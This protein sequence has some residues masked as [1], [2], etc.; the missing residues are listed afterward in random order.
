M[1]AFRSLARAMLKSFLRDRQAVFFSV[2]FPLMFLVLF[3]GIFANQSQSRISM[4]QVGDVSLIDNLPREARAAFDDSFDVEKSDDLDAAIQK[5]RD[6]DVTIA[7]QQQGDQIIAHYSDADQVQSAVAQGT[8]R[9]FI[10]SANVAASGKPPTYTYAGERVEDESLKTIQF[11]TPGLLGW[12]IATS[13]TFGAAVTLVGWRTTR[14]LRRI[15]LSPVTTTSVVAAR[16]GVTMLIALVQMA[17]FV[18][19]GVVAF[20]LQLTGSWYMAVPLLICGTLAFMALGLFAGSV[21]KT[22][23]GA[24]SLAQV[25]VLPMAFLSGSF[26]SLDG[27][28]PWLN[29]TS[30]VLPLRYLN[31]GMLDVM[32]RGLGPSAAVVP[33]LVLLGFAA[34]VI[35]ISSRFFSWDVE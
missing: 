21:S 19:L 31:D 20:G 3:G 28:P 11:V 18:G 14:L 29:V 2:F 22:V 17:I 9:S 10:Q 13:A 8:L 32:V 16:I 27:A 12:A 5:V 1:T 15:R 6:G 35:A 25:F 7:V 26:F 23:E 33:M 24:T 4:V 30:H 34:V